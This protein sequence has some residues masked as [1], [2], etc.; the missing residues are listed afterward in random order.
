MAAFA[1]SFQAVFTSVPWHHSSSFCNAIGHVVGLS[2]EKQV[3]RIR[4]RRVVALMANEHACRNFP[5][6]HLVTQPV[7]KDVS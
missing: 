3:V 6:V 2:A 4:A 1:M 7:R 5:I